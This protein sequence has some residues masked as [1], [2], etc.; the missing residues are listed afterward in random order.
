MKNSTGVT[1]A[2]TQ[3]RPMGFGFVTFKD[4]ESADLA[5]EKYHTAELK[6]RKIIVEHAIDK[7]S[8]QRGFRGRRG[9]GRGRGS[10]YSVYPSRR[11]GYS[12]SRYHSSRARIDEDH[13]QSDDEND[14]AAQDQDAQAY[15]DSGNDA[16]SHLQDSAAQSRDADD[17]NADEGRYDDAMRHD[18]DDEYQESSQY[19][20]YSTRGRGRGIRGRGRGKGRDR[21]RG[22]QRR[23]Y[24][25][26]PH[27]ETTLFVS[28]L[29]YDLTD[30]ELAGLFDSYDVVEVS[31]MKH[32]DGS[33]K[34]YGFVELANGEEQKRVLNELREL[35]I[36]GR[37]TVIKPA[38]QM[39][40]N[41][42]SRQVN[43]NVSGKLPS[44]DEHQLGEQQQQNSPQVKE[45]KTP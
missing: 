34:G 17:S 35:V 12:D 45:A 29:P 18:Q 36:S 1:M 8:G 23:D 44:D 9:R 14:E 37:V 27:S 28:N 43:G 11:G 25:N 2:A 38:L 20:Q 32:R 19:Q 33:S 31:I 21:G 4:A 5:I 16:N 3:R 26:E 22:P 13:L 24:D 41:R 42:Q 7:S 6:G 30:S 39:R 40:Y 15:G 10:R